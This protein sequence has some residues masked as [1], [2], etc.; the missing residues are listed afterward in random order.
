MDN[1]SAPSELV[2]PPAAA[3]ATSPDLSVAPLASST[4][5][6]AIA[7]EVALDEADEQ[8][9]KECLICYEGE[10]ETWGLLGELADV[11]APGSV[12]EAEAKNHCPACRR[13][14]K[15]I[16]PTP[17]W[18]EGQEKDEAFEVYRDLIASPI[19]LPYCP[20]GKDCLYSHEHPLTGYHYTFAHTHQG[21]FS[22]LQRLT[23]ERQAQTFML[24]LLQGGPAFGAAIAPTVQIMHET[25]RDLVQ[26][27]SDLVAGQDVAGF[28]ERLKGLGRFDGWVRETT[29][30][31]WVGEGEEPLGEEEDA[32][33]WY[34]EDDGE[35]EGAGAG[36]WET[37]EADTVST[38]SEFTD[39]D[40]DGNESDDM[41]GLQRVPQPTDSAYGRRLRA[42]MEQEDALGA[43]QQ[44]DDLPP[45][46]PIDSSSADEGMSEDEFAGMP[47]LEPVPRSSRQVR[48]SVEAGEGESED[49]LP[50]L[51]PVDG[52]SDE[53]AGIFS[54]SLARSFPSSSS[55]AELPSDAEADDR[56]FSPSF[57][58]DLPP[59][60]TP[61]FSRPTTSASS[62]AL[63]AFRLFAASSPSSDPSPSFVALPP[64]AS[65]A[66][67]RTSIPLS[68][69]VAQLRL[70]A[71]PAPASAQRPRPRPPPAQ[72]QSR[73]VPFPVPMEMDID[74]LA[75]I[76]AAAQDLE[77]MYGDD[78]DEEDSDEEEGQSEEDYDEDESSEDES[79]GG[80][81]DS[82]SAADS[83]Q[84]D[85]EEDGSDSSSA[86]EDAY[87]L[88][89]SYIAPRPPPISASSAS[90]PPAP[91]SGIR[92]MSRWSRPSTSPAAP[93]SSA[94]PTASSS[95]EA[96]RDAHARDVDR[97]RK[98]AADAAERRMA[99]EKWEEMD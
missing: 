63:L 19:E 30:R 10:V 74:R 45:L 8:E 87:R 24:A 70:P 38:V 27:L 16:L 88:S 73:R 43:Q 96:P 13:E 97:R 89:P 42:L 40:A 91:A 7:R 59:S 1:P 18:V 37:D 32:E 65:L 95:A 12:G 31:E 5:T 23:H 82:E 85:S 52:F 94:S 66:F 35:E 48:T 47:A 41:P 46:E 83:E 44:E 39:S 77:F 15:V 99:E 9:M 36:E 80:E 33:P 55:A 98:R 78:A 29:S 84:E 14:Y 49:D 26:E 54:P 60:S 28:Q 67:S 34:E 51:E 22:A 21:H 68:E 62:N 72:S 58:R 53:E 81:Y 17:M 76:Y 4:S 6:A 25:A 92:S 64:S 57:S 86:E 71:R 93:R 75:R 11:G 79:S 2:A 69:S 3:V 90:A 20:R 50:P 56:P 61:T